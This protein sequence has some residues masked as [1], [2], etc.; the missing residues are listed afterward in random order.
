MQTHI[1]KLPSPEFV[2]STLHP[3]TANPTSVV[4]DA[5]GATP[6]SF[7][8]RARYCIH[9]GFWASLPP[10]SQNEAE[11]NPPIYESDLFTFTTDKRMEKVQDLESAGGEGG[12]VEAVFWVKD[13]MTQWRIKGRAFVLGEGGEAEEGKRQQIRSWMRRTKDD[14]E[15]DGWSWDREI[16]AHFGNL[17][18]GMRGS[19]RNPPSGTP[20]SEPLKNKEW[21]LGQ[22]VEDL[23]DEVARQNFRV[24]VIRPGEVEQVDLTDPSRA[25]RW[26]WEFIGASPGDER[27]WKVEELWP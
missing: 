1:S 5:S 7:V 24:V 13:V 16:T 4:A 25:R 26:R 3:T 18:P 2:L 9:R 12:K 22:K 14:G 27:G 15:E 21:G 23:E 17:S 20:V 11:K 10:N 19:F 6:T 8:P